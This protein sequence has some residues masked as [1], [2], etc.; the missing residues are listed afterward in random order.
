MQMLHNID[1]DI[2]N[3]RSQTYDN[4]SDMAGIYTGLQTREL[5]VNTLTDHFPCSPHSLNILGSVSTECCTEAISLFSTITD[6]Y[7]FLSA[8]PQ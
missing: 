2:N 4:T 3:S 7:N 6:K 8:S 1:I 5:E